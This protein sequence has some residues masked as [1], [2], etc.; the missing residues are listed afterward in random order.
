MT[1]EVTVVIGAGSMGQA[2]ARRIGV[3]QMI[4]L[5][6]INEDNAKAAATALTGAGY[7]TS[8]ARVD[9]SSQDSVRELADTAAG[10]GAVMHVVQ[11]AGLSPAQASPEAIIAVDLVGTAHVLD[12]FARVIAPGGS[13]I[14]ISSQAGH[15][16]PALPADQNEALAR[17]PAGE[18]AALPFLQPDTITNSG[19]AYAV[20]KRANTLR[21]QAAAV[22]WGDRGAR[23][24][25]LSP[26]IIMTPLALDELNSPAGALYQEMIKASASGRVGTPDEIGT[27]AAFLMGRDGSFIT[28]SDLLIDGGVI[29]SIAAGRFQVQMG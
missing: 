29:A 5:A 16:I 28:G 18:L 21:T 1:T 20:A 13:G 26:G 9:V 8:T 3:G 14:V 27:V 17:T 23:V 6:D 25:S 12:E 22:T 2:I 10:L 24:N 19:I 4:L 11:T 15:M 7:R